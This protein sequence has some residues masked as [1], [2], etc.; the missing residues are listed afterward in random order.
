MHPQKNSSTATNVIRTI[1]HVDATA[2]RLVER[3]R[4][5]ESQKW[6]IERELRSLRIALDVAG[7][8]PPSRHLTGGIDHNESDYV[9]N[10]PFRKM[11]LAEMCD[12]ILKDYTPE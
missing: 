7:I 12:R 10:E 8:Q 11:T 9:L 6:R 5:L 4:Q 3:M 1:E 2:K